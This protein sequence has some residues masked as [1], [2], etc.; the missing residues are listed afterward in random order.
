MKT[1]TVALMR[2][3]AV[4]LF[5]GST[6][7]ASPEQKGATP[8]TRDANKKVLQELNFADRQDYEDA[9]R[10]L[11]KA[12]AMPTKDASGKVLH[13]IT[14]F[15]F[16]KADPAPDTVNPSLWRVAQLNIKNGLFK[17]VD[18]VYQ[19]R[20]I[21]ISNM[22]IIEGKEGL[23]L[24]DPLV[25][26]ETAAAGLKLYYENVEQPKSGKRPVKAVI[27]SHSHADHFGGVRGVIDE[28]DVKAGK[29]AVLAP[30]GFMEEAISENI[31][32]GSAMGMRTTYMYGGLLSHDD[33]GGVGCGLGMVMAF[34]SVTIIQPNDIIRKTG[35]TRKIDGVDIEFLMAPGTEAPAEMIMYFPQFKALCAAEDA[36]HTQHNLYTLR[37]AKVRDSSK[38][39]KALEQMLELYGDKAEVLFIQHHWPRWGNASIKTF[40]EN[41]RDGYKYIHD[42][43]LNLMNKGYTPIEIA[44]QI[45]LPPEIDKQ[46]Y[47]RGYYG[48]LNHNSKAV[49]QYYL[50]WYDSNPA[51]LY[52]LPPAEVAKRY[53]AAMG[54]ADAA[55]KTAKDAYDK[56]DYRW[57]AE[58]LKHVVFADPT[59]Q[60]ARHL[61][62]DAFEQLGYQAEC[63]TW[64]NEFLTGAYEL[65]HN[66]TLKNLGTLVSVDM[67]S[68]L[69][70]EMLFDYAGI[71]L[72]SE[73]SAGKNLRFNWISPEG[74]K[75][76]FWIENSVLMYRK[77]KLFEKPDAVIKTAKLPFSLLLMNVTPLEKAIQGKSVTVEGNQKAV[78][79]LL[80]CL[81][82]FT[83]SFNIVTP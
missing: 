79:E 31:Y 68:N 55:I 46:W 39:W 53:V 17:V 43:T 23:I 13:N 80:G 4:A 15:D 10:G 49:Y 66:Q 67:L 82:K 63:G 29:V 56:G 61:Q 71:T 36:T 60:A 34:G 25:V 76:G 37:G 75:Y 21:D 12:Y 14:A 3:G 38:W 28:K 72:N 6:L 32:A 58:L 57:V 45:K 52:P 70:E 48:S 73:R 20:G 77:D 7:L 64:R 44:E 62:A 30:E 33:K 35:E 83:S 74:Q 42:Q 24:I 47:M 69:T 59:N 9:S 81:D 65:R 5:A 54:G 40:L 18:G 2:A 22:T 41:Q 8:F 16:I 51:N 19:V 1:N 26:P 78:V 27:Y 11:I 50:G